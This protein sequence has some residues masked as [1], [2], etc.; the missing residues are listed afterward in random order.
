MIIMMEMTVNMMLVMTRTMQITIM[1]TMPA[2]T[3]ITITLSLTLTMT[4]G[5]PPGL[6]VETVEPSSPAERLGLRGGRFRIII[7]TDEFVLGGDIIVSVGDTVLRDRETIV[8]VVQSMKVGDKITINYLRDGLIESAEVVL[9]ERPSLPG[10][11]RR[12]YEGVKR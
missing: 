7:G 2:S 8:Q 4:M 6:L 3:T 5:M 11:A 10:D 12:F 9:P 1:L